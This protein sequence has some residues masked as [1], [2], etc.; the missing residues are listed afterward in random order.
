M[1]HTGGVL[2]RLFKGGVIGDSSWIEQH[3]VGEHSFLEKST[4]IE[5][6]IARRQPTQ[7]MNRVAH[8]KHLFVPHVLAKHASEIPV[9][10]RMRI[11]FCEWRLRCLRCLI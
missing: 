4:A 6:E 11:R 5:P 9:S 8:G 1:F 2:V 3:H 7:A 10:S